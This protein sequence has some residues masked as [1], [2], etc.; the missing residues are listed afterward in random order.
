MNANAAKCP[1]KNVLSDFGLGILDD[2]AAETLS[3]HLETCADCR[4]QVAGVAGDSFIKRMRQAVGAS[5]AA[6]PA[7]SPPEPAQTVIFGAESVSNAASSAETPTHASGKRELAGAKSAAEPANLTLP[8]ALAESPDF[9]VIKA[10]GQGGMGVVYL[11]RNRMMDRLEVLKVVNKAFL[12]RPGAL[13]RF[14][15]EIRSAAKLLHPNIVAAHSVPRLGDLLVFAMEYVDGQDL[16]QVVKRRGPLPVTNA[17]Y[18]AYQVALGLQHAHTK[19]MVHRDIKPSNLMF[20]IEDKKHVVKILDFGLAKA[21]SEKAADAGLTKTGQMLG[22]PDYIAPEQTLDAQKA[23]IRADIYSLGCTLYFML[24][25]HPPFQGNS[26]YEILQAHHQTEAQPL[27]LVRADVPAELAAIVSKMMA[28]DPANRYQTPADVAKALGPFFKAAAQTVP[29]ADLPPPASPSMLPSASVVAAPFPVAAQPQSATADF[30]AP[31]GSL[32][33]IDATPGQSRKQTKPSRRRLAPLVAVGL[34][35]AGLIG[36]AAMIFKVKTPEG[37]VVLKVNVPNADVLVDGNHLTVTWADGGKQAEIH[38]PLGSRKIE[39]KKDGFKAFGETVSIADGGQELLE[40]KLEPLTGMAIALRESSTASAPPLAIAPF[41]AKQARA[42]QEAW[43]KHLGVPVEQTNSIGMKLV[44]IPPGEFMMGAAEAELAELKGET[45]K[46][47]NAYANQSTPQHRV[48]ISRPLLMAST[49]ATVGQFRKF[50]AATK[51]RTDAERDGRGGPRHTSGALKQSP[52]I[53]WSNPGHEQ[54]DEC[55]VVQISWNDAVEFCNW[56][57]RQEGLASVYADD[58]SR[59]WRIVPGPG[60]RLPTDAEWEFACRAGTTTAYF[61]GAND[62]DSGYYCW[63]ARTSGEKAQPVGMK[64]P[65]P[66]GLFDI[67]G[68]AT[69]WAQD[70]YDDTYFAN[71]QTVDPTGPPTG[72]LRVRRGSYWDNGSPFYRLSASRDFLSQ[73]GRNHTSG[74][75]VARSLG[76]AP[77]TNEPLAKREPIGVPPLA[78]DLFDGKSLAGW[79]GNP[80]LC[81]WKTAPSPAKRPPPSRSMTILF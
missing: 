72:N 29:K 67:Q 13:E 5:P 35:V 53:I 55:P 40:A 75:R 33:G 45:P 62:K 73:S 2:R 49:E 46:W 15:Q 21:T 65:N 52:D 60:Y 81:A 71:S 38:V 23:D 39:L 31:L 7:Q 27:N 43:A 26:L 11:A 78:I 51:Y 69:E 80:E 4:A 63:Y 41:D 32:A 70:W 28:K 18:Y 64:L 44:L 66:F 8:P 17:T 20:A 77:V 34:M 74:F 25:G 59:N 56:L 47:R 24:S 1:P 57:S 3:E 37:I 22:T 19:G 14:Q 61:W 36:A 50:V 79:D 54:N 16:S 12:D 58:G 30:V 10:L 42:H 76:S 9:E 68:N 48:T 6:S